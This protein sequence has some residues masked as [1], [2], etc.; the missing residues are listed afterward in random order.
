VKRQLYMNQGFDGDLLTL[1]RDAEV[2]AGA[3]AEASEDDARRA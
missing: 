3:E 2:P 1:V